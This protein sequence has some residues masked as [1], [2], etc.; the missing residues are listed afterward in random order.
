LKEA[1]EE[2]APDLP[3]IPTIEVK[4][5]KVPW[6][7]RVLV[8]ALGVL[9]ICIGALIVASTGGAAA[10]F[11]AFMIQSGVTDCINALFRPEVIN[12]LKSYYSKKAL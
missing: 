12:D 6:W 4:K 5:K 8:F 3:T 1:F 2:M 7:K 11:G 10:G 9:Q